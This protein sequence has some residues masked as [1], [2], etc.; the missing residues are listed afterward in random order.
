M[1][2]LICQYNHNQRVLLVITLVFFRHLIRLGLFFMAGDSDSNN[3]LFA[4]D[5]DEQV[6]IQGELTKLALL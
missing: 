4:D 2:P 6:M 1:L 3:K 5:L